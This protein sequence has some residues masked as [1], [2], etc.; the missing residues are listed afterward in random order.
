MKKF[1]PF[2]P[3]IA[4][5]APFLRAP[6][7][8]CGMAANIANMMSGR[9]PSTAEAEAAE[10]TNE[11]VCPHSPFSPPLVARGRNAALAPL[12][13][14]AARRT[15]LPHQE[16]SYEELLRAQFASATKNAAGA[17]RDK[18]WKKGQ[19]RRWGSAA[20][21]SIARQAPRGHQSRAWARCFHHIP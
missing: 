2:L 11:Q 10:E 15:D 4:R 18:G 13:L 6:W 5:R 9:M 14:L 1:P 17:K 19:G 16:V 7:P 3:R 8:L 21:A 20:E 12:P